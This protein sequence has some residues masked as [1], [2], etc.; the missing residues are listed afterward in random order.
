VT[1]YASKTQVPVERSRAEIERI[2][3]R[4]GAEQFVYG[5]DRVGAIIGFLVT[6]ESDQKRQ[7]KFQLPLPDR[8]DHDF[9][10]HS[11]GR[12][13]DT[14]AER[15]WEQACRQRWRALAL[16]VKAKLEAVQS[17]IATF[18]DEF[19]A[20]TMLPGGETVGQWLTPQLDDVYRRGSLPSMLPLAL[21]PG[22]IEDA[23]VVE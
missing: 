10:H 6:T 15:L 8:A 19:L 7:V 5:W 16:V 22:E 20:Y 1:T 2:L 18:E 9:T 3:V 23:E 12:R 17:G 13:T 14:E 11:R 4:Y 21:P